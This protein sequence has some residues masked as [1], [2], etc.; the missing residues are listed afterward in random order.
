MTDYTPTI[1]GYRTTLKCN[2]QV[3]LDY[4]TEC[5]LNQCTLK[6]EMTTDLSAWTPTEQTQV[7][8]IWF[9]TITDSTVEN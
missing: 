1:I 9:M 6:Y 7:G 4:W 8:V 3:T 2:D 5:S